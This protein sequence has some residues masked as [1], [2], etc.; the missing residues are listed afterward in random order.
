MGKQQFFERLRTLKDPNKDVDYEFQ[1]LTEVLKTTTFKHFTKEEAKFA[2][3][4]LR[5][6]PTFYYNEFLRQIYGEEMYERIDNYID[7]IKAV[8]W[9]YHTYFYTIFVGP[10]FFIDGKIKGVRMSFTQGDFNDYFINS[11]ISHF[12]YFYAS[13]LEGDYGNYPRGR[14]IYN[15]KTN[16]FYI[17]VDKSL[18]R[19]KDAI[20]QIMK[21]YRLVTNNTL[22][23]VDEHYTHDDL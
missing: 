6:Y 22:I 19:N 11:M 4:Y 10:F 9:E 8:V 7:E 13:H 14:V 1:Y 18:K 2:S 12:T 3:K 17:Y 20:N 15:N 16:E 21:R 5:T 23:K